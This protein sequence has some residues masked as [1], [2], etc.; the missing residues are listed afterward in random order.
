MPKFIINGKKPLSGQIA[1]SGAKN[2]ALKIIPASILSTEK[3]TIKNLP[4]IED[5]TRSF[6]VLTD[7]GAKITYNGSEANIDTSNIA[8][9]ELNA[10]MADKFRGSIMFV[11]PLLARFGEAKFPHPGGCVIGA[12]GRPID[13]FL[14][15]YRAFGA[16]IKEESGKFYHIKAKHLQAAEYLF[17]LVSVTA[18]ESMMMTASIIP[19]TTILK[20]CAMEP[21][22][23]ALADYLNTQGAQ[24]SG[25]GTP[26]M[27]IKGQNK[28]GAGEFTVIP[29]R[30]ETGSF[31]ILAAAANANLEIINCQP[32]HIMTL[33]KIMERIGV[34]FEY[35]RDWL[36]I[37]KGKR[38]LKAH[39]IKTHEYPGFAT[40]LQSPYV[41][42]MTQA[43]G[44]SLIHET[45]YDRRLLWT[46]MLSQMGASIIMC[47]PHRV[48]IQGP[49]PLFGKRLISPD[50]RAGIALVIAG[51]IAEGRTEIDNVYQI[52]RGYEKLEER[53]RKIGAD[54][55]RVE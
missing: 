30:I 12:G 18:T 7:L 37:K 22:I 42:L 19:G 33:L 28:I 48:V 27:V 11:G 51:L 20:N 52:D 10:K 29:D 38:P 2:S 50:L 1:V 23:S 40:D 13:L 53:L 34:D 5:V 8:N 43:Q 16:E 54:I 36:K 44:I 49:T 21:E 24:I 15:G 3:I 35:G 46:D 55:S 39:D 6:E 26:I 31:A 17:P 32:E 47:D 4:N 9:N 45:I 14:E 25:A 41:V